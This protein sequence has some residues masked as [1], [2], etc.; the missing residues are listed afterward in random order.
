MLLGYN[1]N[2]FA[3]HR[4]EDALDPAGTAIASTTASARTCS[5]LMRECRICVP[6][7]ESFS[8]THRA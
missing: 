3:H 4:L 8:D 6:P 7:F 1:T 5:G 2:G